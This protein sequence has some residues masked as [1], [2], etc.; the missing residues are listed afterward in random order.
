M[1]F[2]LKN[3]ILEYSVLF[4]WLLVDKRKYEIYKTERKIRKMC[5]SVDE[6][7]Q[8]NDV[9]ISMVNKE[10]ASLVSNYNAMNDIIM[11]SIRILKEDKKQNCHRRGVPYSP[12]TID[13]LM[14]LPE[15]AKSHIRAAEN[16][17]VTQKSK[18]TSLDT[19]SRIQKKLYCFRENFINKLDLIDIYSHLNDI[20]QIIDTLGDIGEMD[21]F[22]NRLLLDLGEFQE[23]LES[24]E[25]NAVSYNTE[26][27]F[28]STSATMAGNKKSGLL[29]S[30]VLL[31]DILNN[32]EGVPFSN[33]NHV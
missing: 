16:I 13:D 11:V 27:I 6:A 32:G 21:N 26:T 3:E 23:K 29:I 28:G 18:S 14:D 10:I 24:V 12:L 15:E 20:T 19:Y 33:I 31:R 30:S 7:I 2:S 1:F 25:E 9:K 5:R 4:F 8:K 22:F 17:I